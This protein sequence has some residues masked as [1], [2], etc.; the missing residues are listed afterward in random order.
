M[1]ISTEDIG[2]AIMRGDNVKIREFLEHGEDPNRTNP[3]GVSLFL[4]ACSFA[5][6]ESV[7]EILLEHGGN[8]AT[9][10]PIDGETPLMKIIR[11]FGDTQ[12]VDA[13]LKKNIDVN[14]QSKDGWTALMDSVG[15]EINAL[16]LS[17]KLIS[18]GANIHAKTK[19]GATVLFWVADPV[20][21][22]LLVD[23][24]ID[25]NEV[26]KNGDSALLLAVQYGRTDVMNAL[27]KY[28]ANVNIR[29]KN[30]KTP[31]LTALMKS[32]GMIASKILLSAGAD[33]KAI[34]SN[35]S[36]TLM[37]IVNYIA[38]IDEEQQ[39]ELIS[40]IMELLRKGVDTNAQ[41]S[42]GVNALML[43]VSTKNINTIKLLLE[44]GAN[45]NIVDS[46]GATPLMWALSGSNFD[47][48]SFH[49]ISKLLLNAGADATIKRKNGKTVLD[50]SEEPAKSELKRLI[51]Q[52]VKN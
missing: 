32:D 30:D 44:N 2:Q 35:G 41:G 29:N 11:R 50:L 25:V 22:N 18:A 19:E 15:R 27:I 39:K 43:A 36:T 52:V 7:I 37:N 5:P 49:E 14:I 42:D 8:P 4:S 34:S 16:S 10:S 1:A 12:L 31:L 45:P 9:Q 26:D 23:G 48:P 40:I 20:L 17:K 33:A 51:S 28:G 24:G 46:D 38:V 47:L 21:V 3:W 6:Q 13:F